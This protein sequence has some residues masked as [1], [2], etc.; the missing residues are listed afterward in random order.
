MDWGDGG[1]GLK[2]NFAIDNLY[3]LLLGHQNL[4]MKIF[5]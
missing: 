5:H 3:D 4:Y 2:A 1:G